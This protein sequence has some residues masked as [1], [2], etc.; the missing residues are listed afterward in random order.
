MIASRI[1]ATDAEVSRDGI[2]SLAGTVAF[3]AM[4]YKFM[5]SREKK[6]TPAETAAR[7]LGRT[8]DARAE[9]SKNH[10]AFIGNEEYFTG[11]N[12]DLFRAPIG[13]PMERGYRAGAR[14]ECTK[15]ALPLWM[16]LY[17]PKG[18]DAASR[19]EARWLIS[20]SRAEE[21]EPRRFH[22]PRSL[23]TTPRSS[24]KAIA[25]SGIIKSGLSGKTP[26]K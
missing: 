18:H 25:L 24:R 22:R 23:R 17:G 11:E 2:L 3:L 15:A 9:K 21:E 7:I 26:R 14:F 20:G 6:E 16:K 4:L 1:T 19:K 5:S 13:N 8:H 10:V 12:G